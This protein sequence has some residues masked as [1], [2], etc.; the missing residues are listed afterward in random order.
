MRLQCTI[1]QVIF[2]EPKNKIKK[3]IQP[4]KLNNILKYVLALGILLVIL[5]FNRRLHCYEYVLSHEP[6]AHILLSIFL[7]DF[8]APPPFTFKPRAQFS[9]SHMSAGLPVRYCIMAATSSQRWHLSTNYRNLFD[10]YHTRTNYLWSCQKHLLKSNLS[11]FWH[12]TFGA[13]TLDSTRS[14]SWQIF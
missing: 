8:T 9:I 14:T 1:K 4:L 3:F 5:I 13:I 10:R 2:T 12:Q 7:P 11:K 6:D